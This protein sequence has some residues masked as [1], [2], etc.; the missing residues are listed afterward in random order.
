MSTRRNK[1]ARSFVRNQFDAQNFYDLSKIVRTT[2]AGGAKVGPEA[3]AERQI[4]N[5]VS[6]YIYIYIVSLFDLN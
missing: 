6:C 3:V 5:I 1:V 4:I 2:L